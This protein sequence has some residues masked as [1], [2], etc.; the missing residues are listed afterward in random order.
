MFYKRSQLKLL[1][2]SITRTCDRRD[3]EIHSNSTI[4]QNC[5]RIS[6]L[7][8]FFQACLVQKHLKSRLAWFKQR[9][10]EYPPLKR[11]CWLHCSNPISRRALANSETKKRNRTWQIFQKV[12]LLA[13]AY[14]K[15]LI[16]ALLCVLKFSRISRSFRTTVVFV[17]PF[18]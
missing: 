15:L 13:F 4:P 12:L 18:L 17:C 2:Q 1:G 7:C 6:H 14:S 16:E 11:F 10:S 8:M 9:D 5:L 3:L